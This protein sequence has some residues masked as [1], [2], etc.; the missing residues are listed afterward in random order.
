LGY[1]IWGGDQWWNWGA[2]TPLPLFL[3]AIAP[4]FSEDDA[5]QS[6]P[7]AGGFADGPWGPP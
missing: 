1:V 2:L 3:L 6:E 4:Q 7:W 5:S